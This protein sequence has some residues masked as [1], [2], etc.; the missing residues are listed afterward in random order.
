MTL[1]PKV[2][3]EQP[4]RTL[5]EFREFTKDLPDNVLLIADP[6]YGDESQFPATVKLAE[7]DSDQDDL[8]FF[9]RQRLYITGYARYDDDPKLEDTWKEI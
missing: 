4:L 7:P 2:R 6:T 5:G 8:S 1:L 9:N 3:G